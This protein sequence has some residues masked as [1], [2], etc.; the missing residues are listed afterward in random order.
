MRRKNPESLSDPEE[1]STRQLASLPPNSSML[2]SGARLR[3]ELTHAGGLTYF[4]ASTWKVP[5]SD[6]GRGF[7][8]AAARVMLR[9]SVELSFAAARV[10][11]RM[12]V[13]L[14]LAS[15]S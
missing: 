9:M 7:L 14:S 15:R 10:T 6:I 8:L 5:G 12:S 1:D 2:S 4:K 11:L 13:V 3:T